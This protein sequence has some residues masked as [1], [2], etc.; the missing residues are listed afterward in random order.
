[1]VMA[2]TRRR[3]SLESM[4][5]VRLHPGL[6]VGVIVHEGAELVDGNVQQLADF[7]EALALCEQGF[8]CLPQSQRIAL[9]QTL[10]SRMSCS[11]NFIRIASRSNSGNRKSNR[12]RW[13]GELIIAARRLPGRTNQ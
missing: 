12:V 6:S 8:D 9:F 2:R 13:F 1:M 10:L 4:P 5:D 11:L 3:E 7:L